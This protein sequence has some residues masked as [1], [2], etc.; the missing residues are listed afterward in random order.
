MGKKHEK[1]EKTKPPQIFVSTSRMQKAEHPSPA[2]LLAA[3]FLFV[4][5]LTQSFLVFY[6]LR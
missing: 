5:C 3:F 4:I 1:K 2:V 6:L